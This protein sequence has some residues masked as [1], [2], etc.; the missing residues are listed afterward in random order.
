MRYFASFHAYQ[1]CL[2]PEEWKKWDAIPLERRFWI[3]DFMG[4][5]AKMVTDMIDTVPEF[6]AGKCIWP[7]QLTLCTDVLKIGTR[8]LLR[9]V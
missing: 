7:A 3:D 6:R 1:L 2:T 5:N 9:S 4:T 8:T